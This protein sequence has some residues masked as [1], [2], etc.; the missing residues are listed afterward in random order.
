MN[1]IG[2]NKEL[3]HLNQFLFNSNSQ[4]LWIYGSPGVGKTSLLYQF[5]NL[6]KKRLNNDFVLYS[7]SDFFNRD[8]I[9]RFIETKKSLI[10]FDDYHKMRLGGNPDDDS[11]LK[12]GYSYSDIQVVNNYTL[13]ELPLLIKYYTDGD[14]NRK[15]IISTTKQPNKI[16]KN[17]SSNISYLKVENFSHEEINTIIN[18]YFTSEQFKSIIYDFS[19]KNLVEYFQYNTNSIIT[20]LNEIIE[21]NFLNSDNIIEYLSTPIVQKGIIGLDGKPLS[22]ESDQSKKIIQDINVVNKSLAEKFKENPQLVY[23]MSPHEFELLV[24]ELLEKKGFKINLTKKTH[25][26]GKDIFIAHSNL[27]GDFMYYVECKKYAPSNH[28]G[29]NLVRELYGTLASDRAT[30]ALLVTSSYFSQEA[31]DFAHKHQYQLS[32]KDFIDLKKW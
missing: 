31:I 1:F 17:S 11:Y 14:K 28:V 15:V 27:I 13:S 6:N 24:A 16:N 26:G 10:I 7:S 20:V 22:S 12:R 3:E 19:K 8:N 2:R 18:N 29:V 25:D 5:I 32:L 4:L 21:N 23:Q 9:S 30:A